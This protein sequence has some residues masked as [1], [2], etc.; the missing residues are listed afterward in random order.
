MKRGLTVIVLPQVNISAPH[1]SD[2]QFLSTPPLAH[3]R[4]P[5][6]RI[7]RYRT[8]SPIRLQP[9]EGYRRLYSLGSL[10]WKQFPAKSS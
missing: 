8:Y 1:R 2:H 7:P 3:A 9:R 10:C 6:P 5:Q 4:V